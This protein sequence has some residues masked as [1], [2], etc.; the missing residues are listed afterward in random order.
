MAEF[1][2]PRLSPDMQALCDALNRL[3]SAIEKVNDR[4]VVPSVDDIHAALLRKA[5]AN[6]RL[7]LA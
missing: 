4:L 6:G 3:A 2:V 1:E 5:K 7:G